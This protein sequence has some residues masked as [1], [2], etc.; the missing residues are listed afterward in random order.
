ML[1]KVEV[2]PLSLAKILPLTVRFPLSIKTSAPK[3]IPVLSILNS[4]ISGL[5][6]VDVLTKK[7]PVT[8]RFPPIIAESLTVRVFAIVAESSTISLPWACIPAGEI[9]EAKSESNAN[10][11]A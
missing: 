11:P 3:A 9:Y 2:D 6:V 10:I 7:S 5:S 4:T 1:R 8:D